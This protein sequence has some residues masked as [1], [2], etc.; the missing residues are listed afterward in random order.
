MLTARPDEID[1]LVGIYLA[2]GDRYRTEL[3]RL[4]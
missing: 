4:D 3:R 2:N 1:R